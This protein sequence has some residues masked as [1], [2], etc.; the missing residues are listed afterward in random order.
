MQPQ[1]LLSF[2]LVRLASSTGPLA[3][4]LGGLSGE[5][6]VLVDVDLVEHCFSF[7]SFLTFTY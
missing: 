3:L 1:D 6:L 7:F 5:L 2:V 4:G